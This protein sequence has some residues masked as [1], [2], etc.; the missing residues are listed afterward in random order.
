MAKWGL[1]PFL[2]YGE[3]INHGFPKIPSFLE[4]GVVPGIGCDGAS[5][6]ALDLFT[7]VRALK[8]GTM[9]LGAACI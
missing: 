7:Q 8:A 9:A 4:R 5:H 6:I 2:S 1:I 3:L